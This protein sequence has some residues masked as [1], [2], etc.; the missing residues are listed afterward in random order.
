MSAQEN[1]ATIGTRTAGCGL[2]LCN[3]GGFLLAFKVC[4][5]FLFFRSNPQAGAGATVALT[6]CWLWLVA[7]CTI[8]D[9]PTRPSNQVSANALRWIMLYLGLAAASLTWTTTNSL[10]I[11]AGYWA[12]TAAD[13]VAVWLL[14]RY[15][16]VR[17]N[18]IRIMQGFI[19][20]A[21]LLAIIAWSAPAMEDM[22]LGHED[23]LHPNLIG[24]DFA[25]AALFSAYLA[26]QKKVWT[27]AAA[28]FVVTMIRTLSKG[29]IVGFLFAG[30]YYLVRGLKMSRKARISIGLVS[31]AV[32][33]GFWGLLE[34][35]LDVYTTGS[36]LETLTGRTYIW[37]QSLDIVMEKPWFGHGFDSFRWV[38]P[39]FEDFQ[40]WHAHN[41]LIQQ[42]F[43]YGLVGLVIVLGVYWA[44]YRQVRL[45]TNT[46][47]KSLAMAMLILVLV[48]GLVDTDRFE[49][50]FP[51]WL[52][53]MLSIA[54][55]SAS[56]PQYST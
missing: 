17:Q 49:L 18:A 14:L 42:L 31:A 28:G 11:A 53:T 52:M 2:L 39:P 21:A 16:P 37:T 4:L 7:G 45:S 27:W 47:L 10:T 50:C 33:A 36:N 25:I 19:L 12:A 41:E 22:R 8:V 43:A 32:L 35:Y 30:L 44:F 29:T 5:T 1:P 9:P 40:P 15:Q 38:F 24:F 51:L 54:L 13:V 56:V 6:L 3:I 34:A 48:R 26:Q 55:A 23:F 20:G 46:G